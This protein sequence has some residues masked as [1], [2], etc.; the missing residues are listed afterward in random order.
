MLIPIEKGSSWKVVLNS[1]PAEWKNVLYDDNTWEEASL[2]M[3]SSGTQYF[4]KHF[5]GM[6]SLAAYELRVNY[7][8]GVIFY[9]NGL[10]IYRDNMPSGDVNYHTPAS[11]SYDS[12]SFR[13]VIRSASEIAS[14]VNVLAIELHLPSTVSQ[15]NVTLDAWLAV[16]AS[17]VLSSSDSCFAVPLEPQSL[18]ISTGTHGEYALDYNKGSYWGVSALTSPEWLRMSYSNT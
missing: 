3:V 5:T 10:E 12:L 9:I 13:G 17:T 6:S 1:V 15:A 18:E 2:E 4:R 7:Q 14:V 16:Y 11:A 8:Y